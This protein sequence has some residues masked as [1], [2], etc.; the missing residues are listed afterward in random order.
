MSFRFHNVS[1]S[2]SPPLEPLPP[3]ITLRAAPGTDLWRK[4]PARSAFS[5][6]LCYRAVPLSAFRRARATV[7][8]AWRTQYEQGGLCL[9]LPAAAGEP[10]SP[11]TERRWI[12]TGI[13]R[14]NGRPCVGAVACDRWADW[15]LAP[16]DGDTV[17]VEMERETRDGWQTSTLWIYVVEGAARRPIREVTW[18]FADNEAGECWVGVYAAKPKP[19]ADNPERDLEVTFSDVQVEVE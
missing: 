12:K 6:P 19:D 4:P 9:V 5:A 3:T 16:W 7:A 10:R 1:A 11:D 17:T 13:E 14:F 15:S 8:A 2:A 18:A